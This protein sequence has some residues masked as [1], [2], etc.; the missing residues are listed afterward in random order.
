MLGALAVTCVAW[1]GCGGK[2]ATEYV[3]GFSTQMQVPRDLQSIIIRVDVNGQAVFAR[4]YPVYDGT[5]RLP[6]T[7]GVV[8]QSTITGAPVTVTVYGYSIPQAVGEADYGAFSTAAVNPP[9]VGTKE[10]SIASGG[11]ARILRASRQPYVEGQTLYLPMPLHYSCYDVDCGPVATMNDP[12]LGPL[13]MDG[14]CTCKGGEC[15]RPDTDPATLPPY[16]DDLI[17]GTTNTCFRPFTDK[18]AQGNTLPGCMDFGI[19]PQVI[20]A[21]NC[22]FAQ[23]G[24][25]SVPASAGPYDPNVP[26]PFVSAAAQGGGLN[27]RAVFDNVVSEVLDYEGACPAPGDTTSP[28]PQEGYCVV[29]DAPQRF[30]LAPGLC[31]QYLKA[32][33]APHVISLLESAATCLPKTQFQ[34]ICQDALVGPPQ[35]TLPDG[36]TA[37]NAYCNVAYELQP[38]PSAL[39][40][41]FDDSSGMRDFVGNVGAAQALSLSLQDPVFQQTSVA[42]SFFPRVASSAQDCVTGNNSF[43]TK[44]DIPLELA[45]KAQGDIASKLEGLTPDAGYMPPPGSGPSF[46][47]AALHGAYTALGGLSAATTYNRRAV[48]LFTDRDFHISPDDC[49]GQTPDAITLSSQ[50]VADPTHPIETYVVYLANADFPPSGGVPVPGNPT[51]DVPQLAHGVDKAGSEVFFDASGQSNSQVV[52]LEALGAVVADLGSCLYGPKIRIAASDV[53]VA[54]TWTLS[55]SDQSSAGSPPSGGYPVVTATNATSCDQDTAASPRWAYYQGQIGLCSNTCKRLVSSNIGNQKIAAALTQITNVYHSATGI[56]V[57]ASAPAVDCDAG[58]EVTDGA[59]VEVTT[60]SA[61]GPPV[62]AGG[63]ADSGSGGDGGVAPFDGGVAPLDA[64]VD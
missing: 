47:E 55:F 1:S 64:A 9:S 6:R 37:T 40:V 53:P 34:P 52:A 33:G 61:G 23:P 7:L 57:T 31:A 13:C 26:A 48:M 56:S 51:V 59:V 62:D 19:P 27:V 25:S 42:M 10:N 21:Q 24:T 35:P 32:A 58:A 17:Y 14:L 60:L 38:A 18:D 22:V 44:P 5:V 15:V 8:K 12:R 43:A 49:T 11:G 54:P 20:D 4:D 41:L 16:S 28:G 2:S 30:Q 63:S 46:L 36:G 29:A 39:Y 3:A 50:A 45:A